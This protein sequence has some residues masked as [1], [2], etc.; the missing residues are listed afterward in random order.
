M[1]GS[2]RSFKQKKN[3]KKINRENSFTLVYYV[4]LSNFP[5]HFNV[6]VLVIHKLHILSWTG[7]QYVIICTYQ[8]ILFSHCLPQKKKQTNKGGVHENS[9]RIFLIACFDLT[10][11]FAYLY[12]NLTLVDN[13]VLLTLSRNDIA[14]CCLQTHG[15]S[16]IGKVH[17]IHAITFISLDK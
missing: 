16:N 7:N 5:L 11:G 2:F 13:K 12:C 6:F 15:T 8:C 4:I 9:A 14:G 17:C 10:M 3:I 1:T